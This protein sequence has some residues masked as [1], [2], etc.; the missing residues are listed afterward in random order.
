MELALH[1]LCPATKHVSSVLYLRRQN[2]KPGLSCRA[3]GF[4][5]VFSLA[6]GT[7]NIFTSMCKMRCVS[8]LSRRNAVLSFILGIYK[9]CGLFNY[10]KLFCLV[11]ILEFF[12]R[13][14][15]HS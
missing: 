13:K 7:I 14:K 10:F 6:S 9:L 4:C 12:F 1:C 11:D 15:L 2:S 5:F 8:F 3:R